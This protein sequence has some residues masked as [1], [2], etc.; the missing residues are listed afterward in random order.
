MNYNLVIVYFNK[1]KFNLFRI[2][3]DVTSSDLKD[4]FS[5]INGCFN[6]KDMGRVVNIEY[7]RPSIDSDG[8]VCSAMMKLQR[9]DDVRT[10]FFI[11][12]N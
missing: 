8:S 6:D 4:Q 3:V 2:C 11:L 10:M 5:H 9:D 7:N 1:G 12:Y